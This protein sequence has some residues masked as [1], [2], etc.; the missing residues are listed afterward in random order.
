MS[1]GTR[2]PGSGPG[3]ACPPKQGKR[4]GT[5]DTRERTEL[6][7]ERFA[8]VLHQTKAIDLPDRKPV[9]KVGVL[10]HL[11]SVKTWGGCT[12]TSQQDQT[13]PAPGPQ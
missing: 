3:S 10:T 7:N 1:A 11:G 6:S 5:A 9:A 13:W 12:S 8:S 2:T 4:D